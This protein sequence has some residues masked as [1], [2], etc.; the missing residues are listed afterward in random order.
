MVLVLVL[1]GID[2]HT[3]HEE[4]RVDNRD[5]HFR[6]LEVYRLAI[7]HVSLLT[8]VRP[9]VPKGYASLCDQWK[10]AAMSIPLNIAESAGKTSAADQRRF[11]AIARGS[12]MACAAIV[13][14]FRISGLIESETLDQADKMLGS[15]VRMLSKLAR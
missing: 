11:F 12:A 9:K 3:Q 15:I 13:D 10:R 1:V 7:A 4:A 6:K 8:T 14:I 5:M 2:G